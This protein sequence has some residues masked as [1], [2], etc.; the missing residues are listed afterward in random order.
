MAIYT[1]A[2]AGSNFFA[3]F[4]CGYI[5]DNMGWQWVF[6]WPAIFLGFGFI[7]CFFFMEET[8]YQRRDTVVEG[9]TAVPAPG[10][11]ASN[12]SAVCSTD[13]AEK[14]NHVSSDP[15]LDAQ[16]SVQGSRPMKTYLQKLSLKDAP[17]KNVMF[18]RAMQEVKFMAWPVVFFSG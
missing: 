8:N 17:K 16:L 2:F 14:K 9:V 15:T 18:A 3:P 12:S 11:Q 7:F 1:I 13:K 5:A 4:V 10:A 6:Y